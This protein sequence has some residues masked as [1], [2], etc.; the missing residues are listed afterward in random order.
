MAA[1]SVKR[2]I[3]RDGTWAGWTFASTSGT[4]TR[5]TE[6]KLA[7]S[8]P[9]PITIPETIVGRSSAPVPVGI[10]WLENAKRPSRLI[11]IFWHIPNCQVTPQG[12]WSKERKRNMAWPWRRSHTIFSHGKANSFQGRIFLKQ[13]HKNRHLVLKQQRRSKLSSIK[14]N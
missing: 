1:V 10:V 8:W 6:K 2:S 12:L 11:Q 3:K 7:N 9:S 14:I 5:E 13:I 4:V